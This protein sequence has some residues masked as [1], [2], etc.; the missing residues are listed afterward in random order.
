MATIAVQECCPKVVFVRVIG[1]YMGVVQAHATR[2]KQTWVI[3]G[4]LRVSAFTN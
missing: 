3:I 2:N 1:T 4:S